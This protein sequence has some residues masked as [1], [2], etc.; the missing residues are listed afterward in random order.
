MNNGKLIKENAIH[1]QGRYRI[2]FYRRLIIGDKYSEIEK[3][4]MELQK[5]CMKMMIDE[6]I[7]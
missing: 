2:R 4:T 3:R 1:K 5:K 6:K 7:M